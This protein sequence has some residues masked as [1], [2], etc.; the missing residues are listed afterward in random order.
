[1]KCLWLGTQPRD[2]PPVFPAP[3]GTVLKFTAA[4]EV[5]LIPPRL[6]SPSFTMVSGRASALF[7]LGGWGGLLFFL[8]MG[9]HYVGQ[10]VLEFIE[11]CLSCLRLLL[12]AGAKGM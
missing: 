7:V 6:R 11:V 8:K 5:P 3:F 1:M 2:F 12:R 4:P 9:S 10:T